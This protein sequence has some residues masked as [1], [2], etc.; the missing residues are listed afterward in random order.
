MKLL[1]YSF[2]L[3]PRCRADVLDVVVCCFVSPA[4]EMEWILILN[5]FY[6]TRISRISQIN[7]IYFELCLP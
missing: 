7:L 3:I 6:W 5:L 4:L 2:F 1:S